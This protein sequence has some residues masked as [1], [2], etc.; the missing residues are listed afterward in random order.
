[1]HEVLRRFHETLR[2]DLAA[3]SLARAALLDRIAQ[4][5]ARDLALPESE[6]LP[7][8]A[9]WPQVR[10]GYLEA[11][12]KFEAQNQARFEQAETDLEADLGSVRIFGR[13]DRIDRLPDGRRMVMDYKTGN[14]KGILARVKLPLEDTQLAF[15]AA[16]LGDD[17]LRAAYVSVG[18][19]GESRVV[20]QPEVLAAR[21]ALV[22]GLVDDL[23]RIGEGVPLQALGEGQACEHCAARG[24]CRKD[25]WAS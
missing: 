8:E 19:R 9:A 16:L 20:E 10:E 6:F 21:D 1:V 2:D 3:Q 4:E 23:R 25:F 13:I 22:P 18:E 15:Y 7:F 12:A 17:D 14:P 11:L 5:A 24:L